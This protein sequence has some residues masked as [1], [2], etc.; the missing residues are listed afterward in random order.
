MLMYPPGDRVS[1]WEQTLEPKSKSKPPTDPRLSNLEYD[2]LLFFQ[3]FL[4]VH[5]RPQSPIF[6]FFFLERNVLCHNTNG[7]RLSSCSC[8]FPI[9]PQATKGEK[10]QRPEASTTNKEH[11]SSV[12]AP[13]K[14]STICRHR[15]L[16]QLT[17]IWSRCEVQKREVKP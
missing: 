13:P 12:I 16:H 3:I 9:H 4:V 15:I 11:R 14:T 17:T 10:L 7:C 1:P 5:E 2:F 8:A 6:Q